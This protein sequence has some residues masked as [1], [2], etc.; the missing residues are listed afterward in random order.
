M[1]RWSYKQITDKAEK[2][3][4]S[5]LLAADTVKRE[6]PPHLQ[7]M[8]TYH[9]DCARGIYNFWYSLTCGWQRDGD[10]ERLEALAKGEGA[11]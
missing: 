7:F 8:A 2:Q 3:I 1:K 6:E 9:K 11:A 4:T 5:L 10:A